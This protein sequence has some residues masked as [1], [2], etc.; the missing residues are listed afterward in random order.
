MIKAHK[1]LISHGLRNNCK[2]FNLIKENKKIRILKYCDVF[3]TI[4]HFNKYKDYVIKAAK[5]I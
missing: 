2:N 5:K 3:E 1:F 4:L